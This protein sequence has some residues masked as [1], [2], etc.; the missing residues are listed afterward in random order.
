MALHDDEAQGNSYCSRGIL[1]SSSQTRS[2]QSAHGPYYS[3]YTTKE[4]SNR[5][6][7]FVQLNKNSIET[8]Y[9]C[10]DTNI[11][12][13]EQKRKRKKDQSATRQN[14]RIAYEKYIIENARQ[15]LLS[16]FM[17]I[18]QNDYDLLMDFVIDLILNECHVSKEVVLSIT[19][20]G[21]VKPIKQIQR[22]M[23]PYI[24]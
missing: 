1:F 21:F 13:R 7:T 18:R 19:Y 14:K 12:D 9:N 5:E 6:E 3:R 24:S 17:P 15:N 16:D 23:K 10:D 11:A 22:K 20:E 8:K 2:Y 4:I